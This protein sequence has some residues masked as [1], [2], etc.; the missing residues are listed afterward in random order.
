MP[1]RNLDSTPITTTDDDQISSITR[2]N[3]TDRNRR[4][5]R[6]SSRCSA[7]P[8]RTQQHERLIERAPHPN[9]TPITTR[10]DTDDIDEIA[11]TMHI[12]DPLQRQP[13]RRTSVVPNN[14]MRHDL[15]L[16]P[17]APSGRPAAR[18]NPNVSPH[19]RRQRHHTPSVTDPISR[20]P[21]HAHTTT[22]Q[23]GTRS[24]PDAA[25]RPWH[26]R[27]LPVSLPVRQPKERRG[28]TNRLAP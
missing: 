2:S 28:T 4:I 13:A 19:D 10:R 15:L 6:H 17:H 21:T 9:A 1:R 11:R 24:P 22:T 7:D 23:M 12:H 14:D 20:G 27:P 18:D 16:S 5:S 3:S 25:H 8:T 26:S